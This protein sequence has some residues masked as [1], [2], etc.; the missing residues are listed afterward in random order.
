MSL[1]VE[2]RHIFQDLPKEL[3]AK[4][5]SYLDDPHK[6]KRV[7]KQFC[8][9]SVENYYYT[10]LAAATPQV[11]RDQFPGQQPQT[12]P[13]R[14]YELLNNQDKRFIKNRFKIDTQ[15]GN[16]IKLL[17]SFQYALHTIKQQA[18]DPHKIRTS[19]PIASLH[20][21]D[22]SYNVWNLCTS[23]ARSTVEYGKLLEQVQ[24]TRSSQETEMRQAGVE[25]PKFDD[26]V[27]LKD[28]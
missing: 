26:I 18:R 13:R 19:F 28:A 24:Q 3:S 14:M 6:L 11:L 16:Y 27:P 25:P 7:S 5:M 21:G 4:V 9:P 17:P 8:N 12:L 10:M 20:R 1:R 22:N 2:N 23:T 15:F